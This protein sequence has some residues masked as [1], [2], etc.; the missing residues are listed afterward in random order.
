MEAPMTPN[1]FLKIIQ[2]SI[3]KQYEPVPKG[4][5]SL[6]QLCE[7]W[8]LKLTQSTRKIRIGIDLG[9]IEKRDFY[10]ATKSNKMH[11]TPHYFF[12][13]EKKRKSKN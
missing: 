6:K 2:D 13:D 4:W 9:I 5:Y 1:D 7:L 10:T 8:N 3:C 11:V 12:H